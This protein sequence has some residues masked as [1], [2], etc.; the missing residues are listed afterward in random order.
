MTSC[1]RQVSIENTIDQLHHCRGKDDDREDQVSFSEPCVMEQT[2]PSIISLTHSHI[3]NF[4]DV[5]HRFYLTA[6][7]SR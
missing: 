5:Q 2:D 3:L 6:D 1:H 7:A 4:H